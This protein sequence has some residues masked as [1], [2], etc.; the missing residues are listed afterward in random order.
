MADPTIS[1]GWVT[2]E[3]DAGKDVD[4]DN[5]NDHQITGFGAAVTAI[6]SPAVATEATARAAAD[7]AA[8]STA[9]ADATSK[10]AAEATLARNA[11]NLA[12]GTVADARIASTI[13]RDSEVTSAVAGEAT[14]RD[15]A[16][17]TAIGA[18]SST[19]QPLDSDLTAIAALTTTAYGRAFLALADAAAGRTALGLGTASTHA[20]GDYD[21]AGAA[22]AAQSASQPLD[23]DLT[24]IAALTTTAFGRGLLAL[25]DA[26][27]LRTAAGLGTAALA[28][29]G[30][31]DAAGA[32]VAAQAASQ[33]L[34]SDLTAIA[35]LATTSYGRSLLAL[36][37]AA[38][39]RTAAASVIG[40]DVEAH[41]A[42]LTT[43]AGL[44][45]TNDD[46]L[47][48]KSG[49]WT[50]R[51]I[52]QLLTD[53]AA[54]GTTFQPLDSDLTSIAALTTTSFG[55]GLLAL[56]DAAA[57]A[58]NHTHSGGASWTQDVNESGA[59]VANWTSVAG[60]WASSGGLIQQATVSASFKTLTY[61]AQ[62]PFGFPLIAEAEI[63]FPTSGQGVGSFVHAGFAIGGL[64][65]L[66]T[67]GSQQITL[68]NYATADVRVISQTLALDTWYK[69][70]A[71]AS[72]NR[73]SVYVD[74]TLKGTSI[75]ASAIV[76]DQFSLASYDSKPDFR[77]VKVWTLSGSAPA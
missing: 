38:A 75:V 73:I 27:A 69:L 45:P 15:S 30:D 64:G 49:A 2:A 48:R 66:L 18:L 62:I 7:T 70:R 46:L 59:S 68:Q 67:R 76:A 60:S 32:A 51:T 52:A 53:L 31:F 10:V 26:A 33:P 72:G 43:I 14:A 13:A 25:A 65:V 11:D 21:A 50:N 22:A 56:A 12:S 40:T 28:A 57:L 39:L 54:A 77:N 16:I 44:S 4:A 23:S 1:H 9:A 3:P 35:A 37:D 20:T 8:I 47:Q 6:V 58:A 19:Y 61:T 74:G 71:V 63:R 17:T 5:L 55:R 29:T 34:D 41:D 36:A 24:A 42:D